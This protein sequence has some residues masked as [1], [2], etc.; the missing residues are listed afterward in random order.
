MQIVLDSNG[1]LPSGLLSGTFTALGNYDQC[2]S[3]HS[4]DYDIGGK[5]CLLKIRPTLPKKKKVIP[6]KDRIINLNNSL[7]N[8]KWID[9]I[10]V[11]NLHYFYYYYIMI[12]ICVP[13][14]CDESDIKIIAEKCKQ[15]CS[16][17]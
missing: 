14:T 6:F 17:I 3:I 4:S 11:K 2:L 12:G 15:L 5:Y 16:I 10:F 9:E 7:L 8:I 13:S 1:Y